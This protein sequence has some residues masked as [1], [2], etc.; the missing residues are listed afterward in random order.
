MAEKVLNEA[1][2]HCWTKKHLLMLADTLEVGLE[3]RA[4]RNRH[5]GD[6]TEDEN[7]ILNSAV[8]NIRRMVKSCPF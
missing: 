8:Y 2:G 5:T 7:L 6:L 3:A 1:F 4:S